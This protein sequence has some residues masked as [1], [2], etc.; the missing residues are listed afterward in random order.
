MTLCSVAESLAEVRRKATDAAERVHRDP[1]AVTIV[2][3]SKTINPEQIIEAF[4]AGARDFGESYVQEYL[5]KRLDPR[6]QQAQ[7]RWHYIGHLQSNKIPQVLGNFA[8]IQSVDRLSLAQELS[9]RAVRLDIQADVLLQVKLDPGDTKFGVSP[10]DA[11]QIADCVRGLRGLTLIGL[12]G[13]AP[14][15]DYPEMSRPYF[16]LLRALFDRLPEDCRK[17]LSMGMTRDF[18]VAIEE[19]ATMVRVGTAI[20]GARTG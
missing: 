6:M 12:M 10:D 2:A 16:K 17:V 8:L 1:G 13:M 15:S 19:G 14:F 5:S 3:V 18:E 9:K 4:Q 7:L 11:L 20:F